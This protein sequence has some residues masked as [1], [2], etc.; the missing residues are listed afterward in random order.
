MEEVDTRFASTDGAVFDADIKT[1]TIQNFLGVQGR[2]VIPF[3]GM[4]DGVWF[5][6]GANG[7]GKST[8]LEAIAWSQF[9][10]FLRTSMKADF[11]VNDTVAS[12]LSGEAAECMVRLDFASGFS[13]E[14]WRHPSSKGPRGKTGVRVYKNG[15]QL[16]EL[17]KGEAKESQKAL[18]ERLGISFDQFAR[19]V[20]LSSD[21]TQNFINSKA[22]QRREI[23][24]ELL[25]LRRFEDYS[26][27]MKAKNKSV[28]TKLLEFDTRLA[29]VEGKNSELTAQ[30]NECDT[31]LK[32]QE[33]KIKETQLDVDQKNKALQRATVDAT[34]VA[35][36]SQ[37]VPFSRCD[38]SERVLM[39]RLC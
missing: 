9:D 13:I 8:I 6:D 26:V 25:G 11:A 3:G 30:L 37:Y 4:E 17:E 14:R 23:I 2:I 22:D 32:I 7:A 1:I 15:R 28:A 19:T 10:S 21:T 24:E 34:R 38:P 35:D 18:T 29:S 39:W 36:P 5:I 31:T 27:E 20:V 33:R 12:T 16:K